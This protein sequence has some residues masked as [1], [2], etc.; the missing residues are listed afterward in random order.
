MQ[1]KL[2][3]WRSSN[4]NLQVRPPDGRGVVAAVAVVVAVAVVAGVA[5]AAA[6]PAVLEGARQVIRA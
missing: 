6:D 3:Q 4:N 5:V 2:G 1:P